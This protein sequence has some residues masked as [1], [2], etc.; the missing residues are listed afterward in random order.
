[1]GSHLYGGEEKA[2]YKVHSC[3]IFK[4]ER[5][6][7]ISI[8]VLIL[9]AGMFAPLNTKPKYLLI[10]TRNKDANINEDGPI[11][12]KQVKDKSKHTLEDA[13]NNEHEPKPISEHK[14]KHAP[15]HKLGL[16]TCPKN[17]WCVG[18][19]EVWC[20][21]S[22]YVPPRI[23]ECRLTC[24]CRVDDCEMKRLYKRII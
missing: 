16:T 11:G 8:V 7:K 4:R 15:E 19:F 23:K 12:K 21:I 9:L 17:C 5:Y 10:E 3:Q 20:H 2:P 1:M 24:S 22:S 13:P 14:D 6:M 18:G